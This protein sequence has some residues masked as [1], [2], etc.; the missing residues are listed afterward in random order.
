MTATIGYPNPTTSLKA[1]KGCS[2][3]ISTI[4]YRNLTTSLIE[5]RGSS[6]LTQFKN[7]LFI[8]K[9]MAFIL[10]SPTD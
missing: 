3:L 4:G 2:E 7:K 1:V 10:R 6:E 8:R 5:V 9:N